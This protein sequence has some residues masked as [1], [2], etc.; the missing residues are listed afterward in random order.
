MN[1]FVINK[2]IGQGEYGKVYRAK[3]KNGRIVVIKNSEK[4]LQTERNIAK[5]LVGF[6]V[7]LVYGYRELLISEFINGVTLKEYIR[8]NQKSEIKAVAHRVISNLE[9]IHKKM[10]TFRHHDLHLD[11]IMVLP[12]AKVKIMDFGLSTMRGIKNPNI[13]GFKKDYGIFTDSFFMYDAHM[14]LN[15]LYTEGVLKNV[16]E[17]L[18][19]M[20][21]LTNNSPR[22]KNYRLRSDVDHGEALK[23]FTYKKILDALKPKT[24]NVLKSILN[25]KA[26]ANAKSPTKIIKKSP[27]SQ[28]EAK[29]KAMAFL[30]SQKKSPEKKKAPLK[31]PG[32]TKTK[33]LPLLRGSPKKNNGTNKR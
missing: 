17:T 9:K 25:S 1:S 14:F 12:G 23:D 3:N 5:K 27:V 24:Q 2:L 29:R 8:G 4:N 16:I 30:A 20:E 22:V 11:N 19:P 33:P 31:K 6:N 10:S 18:L 21:Y 26:K 32:L 7:P 28:E 13:E 15:S